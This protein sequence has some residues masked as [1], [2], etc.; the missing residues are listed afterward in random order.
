M[1]NPRAARQWTVSNIKV[2]KL[3][4]VGYGTTTN[5]K[6]HHRKTDVMNLNQL[7]KTIWPD[8]SA[9]LKRVDYQH[10]WLEM[11]RIFWIN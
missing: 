5:E 6:E 1:V 3:L 9:E 2:L 10:S 4:V 8:I 11:E 7:R